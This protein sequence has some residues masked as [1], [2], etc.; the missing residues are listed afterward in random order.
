MLMAP[1]DSPNTVTVVRIAA[2]PGDVVLYPGESGDLVTQAP[3]PESGADLAH[4]LRMGQ[5][6]EGAQPVIEGDHDHA[7]RGQT[8]AVR[9]AS[10]NPNRS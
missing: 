10:S 9:T 3:V 5:E 1:A 2:E 8:S 6:A 7:L 4:Q